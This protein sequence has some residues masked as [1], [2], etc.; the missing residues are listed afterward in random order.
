MI[1]FEHFNTRI[2][3]QTIGPRYHFT[4][5]GALIESAKGIM[6][7]GS[8]IL[9]IS[10]ST[11]AYHINTTKDYSLAE[12]V[13][14]E[15]NFRYVM[16]MPFKYYIMWA[17]PKYTEE[18]GV[19]DFHLNEETERRLYDEFYKL[20]KHLLITYSGTGKVFLLGNWEGDWIL[21]KGYDYT[22]DP[23]NDII[24]G[25]IR[26]LSIRQKAI[27]DARG[28]I[29][30]EN[31]WVGHYV[32]VNRPLDAKLN[33]MKRM[34]NKVLPYVK[35]DIVSY[36]CYDALWPNR[37]TEALDYI[38][39][40]ARFTDYFDGIFEK[41]V[42]VGEYDGYR[43]Y[44]QHG[45]FSPE[46]Q[47]ENASTVIASSISWGAPFVL[48]WEYY[49]NEHERL[50]HGGGFWLVDEQNEKQPVYLA[51]R[52][53]LSK[54]NFLK[55][56]YRFWLFRNP[57]ESELNDLIGKIHNKPAALL[58]KEFLESEVFRSEIS[59]EEF[60]E[61]VVGC[62][63]RSTGN[64]DERMHIWH[65]RLKISNS[66]Y[67]ILT[68]LF[69]SNEFNSEIKDEDFI[70]V[71]GLEKITFNRN[72]KRSEL[73]IYKLNRKKFILEE[74]ELRKKSG[75]DLNKLASRYLF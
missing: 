35:L 53:I 13:T 72:I 47:V 51:H 17:Q 42:F 41:K 2:G 33:G 74:L 49:N 45:Y 34:T 68:E 4:D 56:V 27:E 7:M 14:N 31:V 46:M 40:N 66:R 65:S 5:E 20:T 29:A 32:E 6:E 16:E 3:T 8:D 15:Q 39:R 25:M 22:E 67:E 1:N 19:F 28:N 18:A 50:I 63:F 43:D 12:L 38:E 52:D 26:N 69:D 11:D 75:I 9:K 37:L 73:W 57:K 21:L 55:N 62:L 71:M 70:K 24:Q 64:M 59:V 44:H 60:V 54:I 36:S 61:K 10:L 30:H 48:Y 23:E 58:L